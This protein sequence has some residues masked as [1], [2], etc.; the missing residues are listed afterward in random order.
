MVECQCGR[1]LEECGAESFGLAF[2]SL[3]ESVDLGLAD[4]NVIDCDPLSK[5]DEM[6]RSESSNAK[7]F[8]PQQRVSR[9]DDTSLSVC[10]RDMEQSNL[11]LRIT[12]NCEESLRAFQSKLRGAAGARE[13][14]I[15]RALVIGQ[16]AVQPVAA[17]LPLM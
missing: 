17:G 8:R 9:C 12:K 6:W 2:P 10:A 16:A 3:Q 4:L 15:E 1:D 7:T 11:L 14:A 13:E 5:I